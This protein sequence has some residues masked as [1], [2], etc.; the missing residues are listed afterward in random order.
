MHWE[1]AVALPPLLELP[2]LLPAL[3]RIQW[4]RQ[5]GEAY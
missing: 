5:C 4:A 1:A 3:W 2:C